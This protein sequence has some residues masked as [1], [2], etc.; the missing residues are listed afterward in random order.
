MPQIIGL[1]IVSTCENEKGI[2]QYG[3]TV[4]SA[5]DPI[6][7]YEAVTNDPMSSEGYFSVAF[8]TVPGIV[9]RQLQ[10][11]TGGDS[12]QILL[13]QKLES[14]KKDLGD[15]LMFAVNKMLAAV[16]TL[17]VMLTA[18]LIYLVGEKIFAAKKTGGYPTER[19]IYV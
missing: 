7:D 5:G 19:R 4:D 12:E 18:L 6:I 8:P 16:V 11:N 15:K 3:L 2:Y 13:E 14:M 1:Q 17:V 9:H 10:E